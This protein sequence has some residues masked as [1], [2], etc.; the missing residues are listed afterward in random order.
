MPTEHAQDAD[1]PIPFALG[2]QYFGRARIFGISVTDDPQ[3]D[4]E[5]C[6]AYAM[7]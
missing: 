2:M 6:I 4:A 5:A 7:L 3:A 1:G